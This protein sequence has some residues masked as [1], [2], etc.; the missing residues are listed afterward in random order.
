MSPSVSTIVSKILRVTA[1]PG[2]TGT[3][4]FCRRKTFSIKPDDTLGKCFHPPC[5]RFVTP[6]QV[7]TSRV[8]ALDSILMEVFCD[9]HKALL[10][11]QDSTVRNAYRYCVHERAIHPRVVEHSMMGVVPANYDLDA[12][13]RPVLEQGEASVQAGQQ[14]RKR[15]RYHRC[16]QSG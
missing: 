11:Q 2:A 10:R 13:F 3:C 7:D 14:P 16:S 12:R 15:G 9:F 5:S 6:T 4:P 8:D 1:R